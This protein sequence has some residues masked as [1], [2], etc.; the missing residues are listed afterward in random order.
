[1][2]IFS[3]TS[4]WLSFLTVLIKWASLCARSFVV[5]F[6]G[7]SHSLSEKLLQLFKLAKFIKF[8]ALAGFSMF[9]VLR[10]S[11]W[12]LHRATFFI[13]SMLLGKHF[14]ISI[15]QLIGQLLYTSIDSSVQIPF[16]KGKHPFW[17]NS[18][19]LSYEGDFSPD[20]GLPRNCFRSL[21]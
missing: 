13:F 11:R 14:F 12:G 18:C 2:K 8:A 19:S 9:A 16:Q 10:V 21:S 20:L 5:R 4:R 15:R 3:T 6:Q 1:M 17:W 7:T